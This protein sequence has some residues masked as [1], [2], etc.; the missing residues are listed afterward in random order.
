[1]VDILVVGAGPTGLTLA[2]AA[3]DHGARVRVVERRPEPF[4]PSR[5]LILHPRTLEVLRPLGVTDAVLDRADTSPTARLH[6]G[7]RAVE[8][9]LGDLAL[10]DTAFP[11]LSLARQTDVEE[12]LARALAERGV[13]VERGTELVDVRDDGH[14]A[15]A[16][17]RSRSGGEEFGVP[18]VA[19]CDGPA[20]TVRRCAGIGWHGRP[21]AVEVLLA[22]L[23][24]QGLA[25][26]AGAQVF[27]A[28]T[29][30]LFLFPLGEQAPWRLLA[31]RA[32]PGGTGRAY[33]QPGPAV[34]AAELQRLLDGAGLRARIEHLAWSARVPLRC[35][36]APRFRR[37]RLFLAGDAAH[38]YSPATG[39]G[40]NAGIQDAVNLGWKL[41]FAADRLD[42]G[43]AD[44]REGDP[45]LDSYEAERRPAARRRLALTHTAFWA[46]ASTGP[47]PSWLRG[48]AAPYAAPAVPFLL[49]RRRLVAE[50]VRTLSQLRVA[51]RH[52]PVSVEGSPRPRGMPRPGDRLPDATVSTGGP[53]QRLHGLLA[54]PGVHVLLQ[55]DA[56]PLP[57]AVPL[58]R[59]TVLR[60]ASSPGRGLLAVR[61]DGHVG[62]TCGTTDP[63][64]L[65][66]WL[67]L[68]GALPHPAARW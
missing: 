49:N 47:V 17:L 46:E 58:S 62:Y 3:H 19:G 51:Y 5:A 23:D 57:D 9:G 66:A 55:R 12:V 39:Q 50:A 45:L 26:G 30:L 44:G 1:M 63:V 54:R 43:P 37:G 36:L 2:L 48:V 42:D 31:T 15:R 22:D 41:A 14:S 11:H 8:A 52:S 28:R 67:S 13:P 29:G 59:V 38:T 25:P 64:G 18:V 32:S 68:V 16:V 33:G 6:L 24:L 61:P 27:A 56:A 34:P 60:L 35:S 53:P 20:S 4:R 10:P 65:T 40:M 21:Y 7:P